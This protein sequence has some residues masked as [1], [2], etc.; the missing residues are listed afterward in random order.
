[1]SYL[2]L[3]PF[4]IALSGCSYYCHFEA[5]GEI[6]EA[7]TGQAVPNA[8]V[9]LLDGD[10]RMLAKP[11]STNERGEFQF[12]FETIPSPQDEITGWKLIL[13]AEG[14]ESTIVAVG[15]VKEPQRNDV[16]AYLVF[17][18]AMRKVP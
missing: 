7:I 13:S 9:K 6:R 8:Q 12:N 18:V 10:G 15:S 14:F 1:M 17:Q 11:V 2:F 4:V 5:R 3:I 16:T